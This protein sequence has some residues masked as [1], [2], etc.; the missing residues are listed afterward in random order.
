MNK[1][2]L[3][4]S[5]MAILSFP[6]FAEGPFVENRSE[7]NYQLF[8][9]DAKAGTFLRFDTR[10]GELRIEQIG[11]NIRDY[12]YEYEVENEKRVQLISY[13]AKLVPGRFALTY[14][15]D[16]NS[17]LLFDSQEGKL[18]VGTLSVLRQR[19]SINWRPFVKK[20]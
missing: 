4:A 9:I 17:Y 2:L 13:D 18:W 19:W 15:P 16:Q 8:E 7:T 10:N 11:E 6:I 1:K 12:C 3:I 5:L 14:L 20:R